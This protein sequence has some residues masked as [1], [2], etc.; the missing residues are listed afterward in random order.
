MIEAIK[1]WYSEEK[2]YDYNRPGFSSK[3]GH[4]TA[5]VW[6]SSKLVGIGVAW[7]TQKKWWVI[8]AN[9]YPAGNVQNQFAKNV[10]RPQNSKG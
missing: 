5:L 10:Q 7:S 3:T 9:Y 6:K 2:F 1:N 8:V 4:F